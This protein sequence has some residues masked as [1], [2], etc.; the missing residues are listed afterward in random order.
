MQSLQIPQTLSEYT[1]CARWLQSLLDRNMMSAWEEA[2]RYLALNDIFFFINFVS[3]DRTIKHSR[4]GT[5]FYFH[6]IYLDQCKR[7]QWAMDNF[8]STFDG[9]ARKGGKSTVR[10]KNCTI[11]LALKYPD[12]STCIFSVEKQYAARHFGVIMEEFE[13][14]KLL[15]VLF[16]DRLFDD[17]RTAAKN[18]ETVWSTTHGLRLKRSRVRNNNTIE[19]NAFFDGGPTGSGYDFIHFDD[20]ENNKAVSTQDNLN[21]LHDSFDSACNL[22]LPSAVPTPIIFITNTFYHPEG[23]AKKKYD[24]YKKEDPKRVRLV[25][26]EDRRTQGNC[27]GG[28]VAVYPFDEERLWQLFNEKKDKDDYAIQ[29]LCDFTSGQDRS[30]SRGWL[31]FYEEEPEKVMKG[32]NSV[33]CIDASRGIYDPMAGFV[34]SAGHD[35]KLYWTGG[36]RKK[37]DPASPEFYDEIFALCSKVSNLSDRLVEIRVEQISNQT[38]ADLIRSEL[39]RRGM[40]T[41]VIPCKGKISKDRI[42]K[43]QTAKLERQWQ[44]WSP[45]LQRGDVVF[46]KPSSMHGRGLMVKNEEGNLFDLVDYFLDFE[47]DLFPRAPNDDVMDAGALIWEPEMDIEYPPPMEVR[48]RRMQRFKGSKTWMSAG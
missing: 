22:V 42:R 35:K 37:L 21:K 41:P 25:P 1:E 48:M 18:G 12:S 3:T 33:V 6:Q 43:F 46:P 40:Y 34:W 39:Q 32:K 47:F 24:E 44:R 28:G 29:S 16:S 30:L 26:A 13:Q 11:Q 20:C 4:Y 17:P 38:W 23:I 36:F 9:S 31:Q 45:A 14:N 5:P 8:V 7:L 19:Y 10:T 2:M 15:K 27:P